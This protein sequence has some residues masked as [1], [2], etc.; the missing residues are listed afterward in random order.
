MYVKQHSILMSL[1]SND[2]GDGGKK[3]VMWAGAVFQHPYG[4]RFDKAK[5]A[6]S[7][8]RPRRPTLQTEVSDV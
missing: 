6:S 8:Q 7:P 1:T 2:S 3:K 4:F 5:Y